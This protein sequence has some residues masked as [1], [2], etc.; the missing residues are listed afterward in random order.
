MLTFS[1]TKKSQ[2]YPVTSMSVDNEG[3]KNDHTITEGTEAITQDNNVSDHH[4]FSSETSSNNAIQYVHTL[5]I[6]EDRQCSSAPV[7]NLPSNQT[8]HHQCLSMATSLMVNGD[9][10]SIKEASRP[11]P[12][13]YDGRNEIRHPSR[14][15]DDPIIITQPLDME[16]IEMDTLSAPADD[17]E[18]QTAGIEQQHEPICTRICN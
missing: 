18:A 7:I 2:Q 11:E 6:V 17:T 16:A 1:D 8:N 10:E 15:D 9:S 4:S 3:I 14:R 5:A 13:F 12:S